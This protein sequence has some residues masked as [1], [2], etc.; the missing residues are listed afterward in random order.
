M[1]YFTDNAKDAFLTYI[2]SRLTGLYVCSQEPATYT[3]AISTYAL[4]SKAS[5]LCEALGDYP[6]GRQFRVNEINDGTVTTT[7]SASH[8]A[9]V[10]ST[11]PELLA[12]EELLTTQTIIMGEPFSVAEFYVRSPDA[13]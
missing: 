11:G 12:T 4:G 5:P 1:S 8:M 13:A 7:G 2:R 6:G 9:L 10:D 3:E